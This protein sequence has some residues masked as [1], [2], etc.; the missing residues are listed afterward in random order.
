MGY[1]VL[2]DTLAEMEPDGVRSSAP[3]C[4]LGSSAQHVSSC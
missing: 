4:V 3:K 1:L 2:D